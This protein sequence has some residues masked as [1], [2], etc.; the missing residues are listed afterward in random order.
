LKFISGVKFDEE[1]ASF[2]RPLL[3][4]KTVILIF[5]ESHNISFFNPGITQLNLFLTLMY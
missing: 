5:L 3:I 2:R 4:Y 1:L